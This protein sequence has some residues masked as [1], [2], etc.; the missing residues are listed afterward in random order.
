M[1]EAADLQGTF[2]G[3]GL[4]AMIAVLAYGTFVDET[5]VGVDSMTVAGWVLAL[6]LVAVAAL[7]AA[8]GEYDLT[9]GFGGAGIGWVFVLAGDGTQVIVGLIVLALS[10]VYVAL[11]TRRRKREA[12]APAGESEP[13]T[14]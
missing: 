3:V 6:T 9:W 14:E 11:V 12:D 8:V 13:V 1:E 7:H 2:I 4:L 5:I 10:A